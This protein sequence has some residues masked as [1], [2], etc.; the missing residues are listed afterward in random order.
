MSARPGPATAPAAR[1]VAGSEP[2]PTNHGPALRLLQHEADVRRLGTE[3]ALLHQLCN[4]SSELVR[5]DV[6][7]VFRRRHNRHAWVCVAHSAVPEVD[8]EA[9]LVRALEARLGELN[10]SGNLA[11]AGPHLLHARLAATDDETHD[12]LAACSAPHGHWVPM[13]DH[14]GSIGAG[15]LYLRHQPYI[16]AEVVLLQRLADTYGHAWHALAGRPR[17]G[18]ARRRSVQMSVAALLAATVAGLVPVQRHVMA[19]MEVAPR[20]PVLI[21]APLNGAVRTMLV[22]PNQVVKAGQPLVQFEDLQARNEATL[23]Q[24]RVAVAEARHA[25]LGALAFT[26]PNARQELASA[27]AEL[28]LARL[29]LRYAEDMLARSVVRAPL[30]GVALYADR[31]DWE[32][33]AVQVGEELLQ[34]AQPLDVRYRV[35]MS[36]NDALVLRPG[37]AVS[38]YLDNA[39]LGG[40]RARVLSMAYTPKQRPGSA[41]SSYTVWAEPVDGQAPRIGG[42][43]TA[44]LYGD[45]VPLALQLLHRPWSA[46]RQT[47]GL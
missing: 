41:E 11:T 19:P 38:V 22:A 4:G 14:D 35:E 5:S 28:K 13:P 9:S 29:T 8:R 17:L 47:L 34:V 15:V 20:N 12:A 26:E 39:P 3:D 23:S 2:T 30:D 27:Y 25:T 1:L 40:Y 32:G 45:E 24:Q 21:T 46:L 33:R 7:L 42:R 31:R 37:A 10:A 6:V 36:I 43:G 44:R 16:P 18:L